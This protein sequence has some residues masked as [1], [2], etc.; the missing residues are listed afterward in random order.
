MSRSRMNLT[1]GP[2][3]RTLFLFSLPVLGSN[4]LQSLNASINS[5]WVG[6]YLGEAALT[7]T[8]NANIVLF[9]LLGVVF[10][11]S[12]ANTILVGQA[13]GARNMDQA[14][15]VVGTSAT[16]FVIVSV[17]LALAGVILTP[18]ILDAMGT[19]ADARP[20]A[21]AYLRVIFI[22]VPF[23]YLY[24]VMMMTLRGTGDSRTPFWFML[25]SVVTDIILNPVLIFG[26]GPFPKLGIAGSAT[27]TLIAQSTS[28]IA[29]MWFLK[30]RKYFLLLG[31]H[32]LHY[33]KPDPAI[34]RSLIFKGLPMGL[35][36]LVISSSAIVMISLVN[37]HGST[38]T[39][40]YGVASQLW[41][42]IQ[43]PA[44]ALGAGVSSMVAQ[45]VGAGL[46]DRVSRITRVGVMFNF[47]MTG[48]LV[49]LLLLLD[50]VVLGLF[51]PDDA[52]AM[53][54][55]RHIDWTVSWSF[56]LFGVT[57]V[58]FATVRAT[59]AVVAPLVILVISMWLTRLPF[60]SLMS[61]HM[62]QEAIWWSF[63]V[64]SVVSLTLALLYYRFGGWRQARMVASGAAAVAAK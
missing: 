24:N 43:M 18:H 32:E 48:A 4:V 25:F 34:L 31:R 41:N 35:Q 22:A 15:R 33:L 40:A 6:H 36:M 46:W 27:A 10:G 14:R 5:M 13:V 8:S 16:F 1:T 42:Y 19:P 44:L 11:L 59:G 28:L 56:I 54:I 57:I 26:W 58:L 49:G 55:A 20:Y 37:A 29:M 50:R 2:V 47:L 7:A 39:A 62:G 9:F 45:N 61:T 64:G 17:L 63:P 12:M 60:A 23:M 53:S 3:G 51:L 52:N 30:R 21:V 38:V